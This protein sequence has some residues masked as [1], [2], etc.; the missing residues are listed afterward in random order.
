MTADDAIA[1]VAVVEA[2]YV[3]LER[4]DWIAVRDLPGGDRAAGEQVA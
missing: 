1:S 3:A 2:A 4:S